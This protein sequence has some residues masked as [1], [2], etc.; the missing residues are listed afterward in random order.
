[1]LRTRCDGKIIV[2]MWTLYS[3]KQ[4]L[5][6]KSGHKYDKERSPAILAIIIRDPRA[7]L[8]SDAPISYA[9]LETD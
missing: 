2:D 1:M 9:L 4:S 6:K 8:I 3:R 5:S 7:T